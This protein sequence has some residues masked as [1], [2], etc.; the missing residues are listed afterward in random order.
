LGDCNDI[1]LR[2]FPDDGPI[3]GIIHFDYVPNGQVEFRMTDDAARD[4]E[5]TTDCEPSGPFFNDFYNCSY[6]LPSQIRQLQRL[7]G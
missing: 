2:D 7:P 4:I 6:R 3:D 5:W 1:S